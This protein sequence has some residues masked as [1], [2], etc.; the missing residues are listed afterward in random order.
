[1]KDDFPE[2]LAPMTR[3]LMMSVMGKNRR[4]WSAHLKGVGSFLLLTRR[5]LL[6]ELMA[7]LA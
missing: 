1:M 6:M 3:M 7:L 4:E 5:G 2:F